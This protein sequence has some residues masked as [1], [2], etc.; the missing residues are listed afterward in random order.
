ML[1]I[2]RRLTRRGL[3]AGARTWR[4]LVWRWTPAP[5]PAEVRPRLVPASWSR[6]QP[7]TATLTFPPPLQC[8]HLQQLQHS[9]AR[10]GETE[11][12][13]R[14]HE[15]LQ[16]W[17]SLGNGPLHTW[18]WVS[19]DTE[20]GS[21]AAGTIHRIKAT[22]RSCLGYFTRWLMRCSV[23]EDVPVFHLPSNSTFTQA[24][25]VVLA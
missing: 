11:T 12:Q 10:A 13:T 16:T 5:D 8:R 17:G 19:R 23:E 6:H 7:A 3:G 1:R 20:R 21:P 2:T 4:G 15:T 9:A 25:D 18:C 14:G 24:N 22:G